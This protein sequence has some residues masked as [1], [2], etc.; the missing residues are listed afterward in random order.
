MFDAMAMVR[1]GVI[2]AG[3]G[4][5]LGGGDYGFGFD[6]VEGELAAPAVMVDGDFCQLFWAGAELAGGGSRHYFGCA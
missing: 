2:A 1:A 3:G 5:G 6:G 4:Y